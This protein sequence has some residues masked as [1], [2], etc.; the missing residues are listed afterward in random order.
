[1]SWNM[2][3]ILVNQATAIKKGGGG[4]GDLT[5]RVTALETTVGDSSSGLVKDVDDLETIVGDE[6]SG[7]VKDVSGLDTRVT[8]L[9]N[10]PS[11]GG[12]IDIGT[13]ETK[14]GTFNG[15]D[16]YAIS[17]PISGI[18]NTETLEL[19][20]IPA[21]SSIVSAWGVINESGTFRPLPNVTNVSGVGNIGFDI[22]YTTDKWLLT[23]RSPSAHASATGHIVVTYTKP[24][25]NTRKG[26][27]K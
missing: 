3:N 17:Y 22:T 5:T 2:S 4:S 23:W 24:A 8:A 15:S 13:T 6:S 21:G 7:L 25:N 14:I 20:G 11:G 12:G 26:G 16:R 19:T 1:M 18:T 9:E 10:E 27:K